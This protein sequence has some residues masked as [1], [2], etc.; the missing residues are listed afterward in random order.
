MEQQITAGY[1][2]GYI[3]CLAGYRTAEKLPDSNRISGTALVLR[4]F[5]GSCYNTQHYGTEGFKAPKPPPVL[6]TMV[7]RGLRSVSPPSGA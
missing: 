5:S 4:P 2:A 6:C 7:P 3:S 1:P